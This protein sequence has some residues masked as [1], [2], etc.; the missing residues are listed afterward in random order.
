MG[1]HGTAGGIS[2]R[3]RS[4]C[5]SS[6]QETPMDSAVMCYSSGN[7]AGCSSR[8][9]CLVDGRFEFHLLSK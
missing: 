1:N 7:I 6:D 3:R 2:E 4:G 9:G 5:S 8:T